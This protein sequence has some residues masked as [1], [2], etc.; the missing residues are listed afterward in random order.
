[1]VKQQLLIGLFLFLCTVIQAQSVLDDPDLKATPSGLKYKIINHGKGKHPQPGDRVWVHYQG[2]LLNDTV[3]A[4]TLK[5][6]EKDFYLG[7]GQII[8]GWE[9]ALPMLKPGG[10]ML[11][12]VP[13]ELGY[14]ED[15]QPGIPP[16]STLIFEI[17]LLQ[18]DK[19]EKI[20]PF[21]VE[22][23][24]VNRAKKG[25]KYI[26]IE[27]GK[28]PLVQPGDNAYVHYTAFLDDG[29]I[30]DSSHKKGDPVRIT[31]G[32]EQVIEG[33]DMGLQLMN[34]GS[35]YRLIIPHKLAYG[36]EGFK[37]RVPPK[38]TVTLDLELV[39]HTPEI[40]VELW[41]DQNKDTVETGS[42]LKYIV[43]SE[44]T[45]EKIKPQDIV[46]VH[47]SG[48]FPGGELFDSSVKREEPIRFPVGV[49]AV[50]KGWDEGMQL[51][52]QG[53]KFQLFIPAE[54]GYGEKG[55]PPTIP[56]NSDLIFDVQV[57]QV[58]R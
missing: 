39:K 52:R 51:M 54:L 9:E 7:Q 10:A 53:A 50:I 23:K 55:A 43:F 58:I 42:G 44:G 27:K 35:K 57:L 6:G 32:T 48:Y 21:K 41:K 28:G 26:V 14:G 12:I 18:V 34:E 29:T 19:G 47:Y 37:N 15:E 36:K 2:K 31:V 40:H 13:P 33:W 11:L 1:M 17:A 49:D 45:G 3:F 25:L 5:T 8:K 20:N 4:N 46:V 30:F 22:G 38:T 16:Q 24:K 56:P